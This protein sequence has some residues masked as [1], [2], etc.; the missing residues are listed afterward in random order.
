MLLAYLLTLPILVGLDLAW[1]GVV[2]KDFY[3]TRIGHLLSGSVDWHAALLFYLAYALGVMYFASY[4]AYLEGSW[5]RAAFTGAL[6]GLFAY[7]TYDLTNMATL[8]NW[9][10]SITVVDILWGGVITGALASAGY[11]L[12]KFLA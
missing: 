5:A 7:A 3:Q 4:P 1:L 6:L 10:M 9:P 2:M 11:F 8:I 12:L